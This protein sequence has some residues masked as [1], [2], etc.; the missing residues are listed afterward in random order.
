MDFPKL[1]NEMNEKAARITP[2]DELERRTPYL[3]TELEKSKTRYGDVIIAHL[4]HHEN[5]FR[6]YLPKRFMLDDEMLQLYN[7]GNESFSL[8]YFGIVGKRHELQFI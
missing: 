8:I 7:K 4:E 3:I 1:L 6:V 2:L 5:S